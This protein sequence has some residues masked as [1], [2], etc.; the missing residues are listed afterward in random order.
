MHR[1]RVVEEYKHAY[2]IRSLV[3]PA[4]SPKINILENCWH[5]VKRTIQKHSEKINTR[6]VV[7]S[8][9]IHSRIFKTCTNQSQDTL[10]QIFGPKGIQLNIEGRLLFSYIW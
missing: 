7:L 6:A 9:S 4:H 2:D 1:D 5:R 8:I 3:W 10:L